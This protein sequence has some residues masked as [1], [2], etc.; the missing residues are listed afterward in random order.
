MKIKLEVYATDVHI[1]SRTD[2]MDVKMKI[3]S[4]DV[5]D[6]LAQIEDDRLIAEYLENK[7][8]KVEESE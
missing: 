5:R 7:G 8:Y 4:E 6:L 2:C 3:E 1:S